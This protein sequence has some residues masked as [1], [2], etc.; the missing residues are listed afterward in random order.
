RDRAVGIRAAARP[1]V[2]RFVLEPRVAVLA[3]RR[4][5]AGDHHLALDAQRGMHLHDDAVD[6][7][8]EPDEHGDLGAAIPTLADRDRDIAIRREAVHA[9]LA[10]RIGEIAVLSAEAPHRRLHG[11]ARA[12]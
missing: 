12:L 1:A 10:L 3:D 11:D 9:E 2:V 6:R 4:L 8:A 7:L 5:V